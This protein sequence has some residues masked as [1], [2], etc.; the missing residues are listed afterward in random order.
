[1][2]PDDSC[3]RSFSLWNNK[4]SR[5]NATL[6]AC[7]CY[8]VDGYVASVLRSNRLNVEWCSLVIVKICDEFAPLREIRQRKYESHK[9]E[10]S[11]AHWMCSHFEKLRCGLSFRILARYKSR[12]IRFC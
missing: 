9:Q 11:C 3:K 5:N 10:E 1:M 2:T 7:V 12:G 4:I 8:V 6:G